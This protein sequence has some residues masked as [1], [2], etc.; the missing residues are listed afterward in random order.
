V[1]RRLAL[2]VLAIA[3]AVAVGAAVTVGSAASLPVSSQTVAAFTAV[4][5][6]P[7]TT[8]PTAPA[9]A[10]VD[11]ENGNKDQVFLYSASFDLLAAPQLTQSNSEPTGSALVGSTLWVSDDNGRVYRYSVTTTTITL[12]GTSLILKSSNSDV[13]PT[14][15]AVDPAA[16]LMWVTDTIGKVHRYSLTAAFAATGSNVSASATV[17][18]NPALVATGLA[19]DATNLYLVDGTGTRAV[20]DRALTTQTN[21]GL[22]QPVTGTS[23]TAGQVV[24]GVTV[25]GTDVWVVVDLGTS[26][27][28]YRYSVAN[29]SNAG[30]IGAAATRS[31]DG[32]NVDPRGI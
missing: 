17:V 32:N 27:A 11:P 30:A 29:W 22:V 25:S 13:H 9:F 4:S 14:G 3:A 20:V 15:L 28:A 19:V 16:N 26:G 5:A 21:L 8:A 6:A 24:Q 2:L 10:V 7:T 31:L 12:T 23:F 18:T 1:S